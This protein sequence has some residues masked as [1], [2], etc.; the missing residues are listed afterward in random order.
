MLQYRIE[1]EPDDNA[2][3]LV[4]SPD[5]PG[6]VTFGEDRADAARRAVD[7]IEE[8]IASGISDGADIPRPRRRSR[9]RLE[10]GDMLVQ[11]PPLSALKVERYWALHDAKRGG[12]SGP[13]C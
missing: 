2:T 5:L 9:L 10:K 7:A 3:L 12:G 11:L 1:L 8:W 6:M 4:T 13:R